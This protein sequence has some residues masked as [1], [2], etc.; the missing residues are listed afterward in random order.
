LA[1]IDSPWW[2]LAFAVVVTGFALGSFWAP[3]MSLLSDEAERTGLDYA[4]G[5]TLINLAWAPAQVAGSAGGA[6][7][8]EATRDAIPYFVLSVLCGLTL[9]ALWRYGSSW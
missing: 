5:F 2:L 4:F 6:A 9:A 3:A 1:A 7:L 8:A